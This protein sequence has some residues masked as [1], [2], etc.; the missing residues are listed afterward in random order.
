MRVAPRAFIAHSKDVHPSAAEQMWGGKP[1][2][3]TPAI[4]YTSRSVIATINRMSPRAADTRN[5]DLPRRTNSR[6]YLRLPSRGY[7]LVRG[8]V[9]VPTD[10][11][12][13]FAVVVFGSTAMLL[14]AF[15]VNSV[16]KARAT[17][18]PEDTVAEWKKYAVVG[19]RIGNPDAKVQV[20]MF[21]DYQC[22]ACKA[23]MFELQAIQRR[24]SR[25]VA[26]IVRHFP[27]AGHPFAHPAARA[28]VCADSQGRFPEMNRLLFMKADSFAVEMFPD[29]AAAASVANA[30]EF[31]RCM[32]SPQ[33]MAAI[34]AD[35]AAGK[36]L[37]LAVTPTFVINGEQYNGSRGLKSI[38]RRHIW[39]AQGK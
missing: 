9:K 35:V 3:A 20:V 21:S 8:P 11:I 31:E 33:T 29:I 17:P 13:K 4:H 22:I 2:D 1:P 10:N 26:V 25:N 12:L 32:A 39:L 23:A 27:I 18:A 5:A 30:P 14:T 6:A 19:Q 16:M 34:A 24:N 38:V 37:N 15:N 36:A 28:A 7:P